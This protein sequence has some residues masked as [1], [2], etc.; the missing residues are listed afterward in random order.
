MSGL[1]VGEVGQPLRINLSEDISAATNATIIAEPEIGEKKEFIGTI[2]NV[3]V[4][5]GGVTIAANEYV[6]YVTSSESDLDYSGRWR[7]KAK[8]KF[9]PSDIRQTDFSIFRVNP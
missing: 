1:N 4:T 2:P 7:M 6:E 3:P 9:S 8:L 5:V